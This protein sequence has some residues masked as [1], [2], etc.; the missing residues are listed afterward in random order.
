M[1]RR[2]SRYRTLNAIP[3][4]LALW[5]IPNLSNRNARALGATG[6]EL[7]PGWAIGWYFVPVATLWKCYQALKEA[8]KAS[9]P[10]FA[11]NWREAPRPSI[12]PRWWT[13]WVIATLLIRP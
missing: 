10:D 1:A 2:C 8:F 5:I 6:M 4:P 7:T 13:L 12:L 11:D 3:V 9:H